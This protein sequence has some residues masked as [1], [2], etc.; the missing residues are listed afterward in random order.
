MIAEKITN[1]LKRC[2]T[3]KRTYCR[4]YFFTHHKIHFYL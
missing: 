3:W 1:F 2:W 4:L